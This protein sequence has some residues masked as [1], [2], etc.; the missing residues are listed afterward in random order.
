MADKARTPLLV[1]LG[2]VVTLS[3]FS[4]GVTLLRSRISAMD[5]RIHT[6]EKLTESAR[7]AGR[8]AQN[9][10]TGSSSGID[11]PHLRQ[12][13]ATDRSRF[14][15]AGETTPE[16]FAASVQKSLQTAGL[17]VLRYRPVSG[18]RK[19]SAHVVEF[20]VRGPGPALLSFLKSEMVGRKYRFVQDLNIQQQPGTKSLLATLHIGYEE[21]GR[22]VPAAA[23]GESGT[24]PPAP[25]ISRGTDPLPANKSTGP[26]YAPRIIA[27]RL[28][29]AT[30]VTQSRA[31][32]SAAPPPARPAAWMSYVGA[33][34]ASDGTRYEFF[35]NKRNGTIL[36]ACVGRTVDGW[37]LTSDS[38]E[39]FLLTDG[40]ATYKVRI[41]K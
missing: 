4:V 5:D 19:A 1:A 29:W 16:R 31:P 25:A 28:G 26:A 38:G 41:P 6:Y 17:D 23:P 2:V 37:T 13:I 21:I 14:F 39:W 30:P 8:S 10:G 15:T 18:E 24:R 27:L 3:A 33:V 12:E 36:R 35:K 22:T 20:L 40:T 32:T 9:T 7:R 11:L 34:T